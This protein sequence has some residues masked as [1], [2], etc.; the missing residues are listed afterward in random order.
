M[1]G[2][3]ERR[4]LR[5]RLLTRALED[6]TSLVSGSGNVTHYSPGWART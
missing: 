4:G 5:A 2:E 3:P 1:T 6:K